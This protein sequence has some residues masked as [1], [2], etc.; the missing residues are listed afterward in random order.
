M[1]SRASGVP[2]DANTAR[3]IDEQIAEHIEIAAT[4]AAITLIEKRQYRLHARIERNPRAA[5]LVKRHHGVRCQACDLNF[6]ERYGPVGEG[7]IEVHHLRPLGTLS[8]DDAITYS[9]A[10]DFAVLCANCH[11][12]IH[13]QADPSDLNVLR[14][15]LRN[16]K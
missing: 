11:R 7:Y 16:P 2:I 1:D 10:S 4:F 14:A 12:M 3:L 6:V 13:R 5:A 8:E 15:I 9:V